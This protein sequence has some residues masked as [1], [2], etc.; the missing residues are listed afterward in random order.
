MNKNRSKTKLSYKID[1]ADLK[2][3]GKEKGSRKRKGSNRPSLRVH[4]IG[5]LTSQYGAAENELERVGS[6]NQR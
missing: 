1:E 5:D 6:P 3:K 4:P 2:K